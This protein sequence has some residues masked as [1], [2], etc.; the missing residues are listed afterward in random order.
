M[1]NIRLPFVTFEMNREGMMTRLR[2]CLDYDDVDK[3]T[4]VECY[5]QLKLNSSKQL[6]D[7]IHLNCPPTRHM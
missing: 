2:Q 3:Q 1:N 5:A 6:F 4:F 7:S